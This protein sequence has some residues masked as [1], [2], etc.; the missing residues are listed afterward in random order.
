MKLRG[1]RR[2]VSG[3]ACGVRDGDSV[4]RAM[5]SSIPSTDRNRGP[6]DLSYAADLRDAAPHLPSGK[7]SNLT[8]KK[9]RA[10]IRSRKRTEARTGVTA[11]PPPHAP[12]AWPPEQYDHKSR[13]PKL[14][15]QYFEH[16]Q[17]EGTG[18]CVEDFTLRVSVPFSFSFLQCLIAFYLIRLSS[19]L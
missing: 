5:I 3:C 4:L 19:R 2:P 10:E 17:G 14:R 1:N 9:L 16:D 15:E 18:T 13:V 12:E 6:I 8:A 11:V 7:I